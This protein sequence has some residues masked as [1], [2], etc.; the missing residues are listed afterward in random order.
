MVSY[1]KLQLLEASSSEF[2]VTRNYLDWLTALPWGEYSDENFVV[3]G[4]QKILDEDHYGLADV[5]EIKGH[6]RTYIGAMP[7]KMVQCLKN[8]GIANPLVL[9]DEIDKLGRGHA[10]D[11]TSALL[12]LLDPEQNA[13]FLDHHLEVPIELSKIGGVCEANRDRVRW[14]FCGQLKKVETEVMVITCVGGVS[15]EMEVSQVQLEKDNDRCSIAGGLYR[16]R[17]QMQRE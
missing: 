14:S 10:G 6:R 4:A 3:T 12:E 5:A 13:N 7:G 11:P 1:T 15:S 2:S 17:R 9:I 8:V 16:I